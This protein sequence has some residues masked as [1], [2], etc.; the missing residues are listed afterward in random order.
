MVVG[1]SGQ[2]YVAGS[3]G[4][5]VSLPAS[6]GGAQPSFAGGTSDGFVVE[7]SGDLKTIVGSTYVGGSD[8][9]YVKGIA[10]APNGNLYLAGSTFSTDFPMTSQG[11]QP[12]NAGEDDA[13]LAEVSADLTS[14][15]RATYSGSGGLQD[16]FNAVL[17]DASGEVYATGSTQMAVNNVLPQYIVV[18]RFSSDLSTLDSAY[19]FDSSGYPWD[20]GNAITLAPD[21]SVYIAATT[22]AWTEPGT[23]GGAQDFNWNNGRNAGYVA[24]LSHDLSTLVQATFVGGSAYTDLNAIAVDSSG[25]VFVG[26]YASSADFPVTPDAIQTQPPATGQSECTLTEL[27]PDLKAIAWSTFLGGIV[28]ATSGSAACEYGS[29]GSAGQLYAAGD[30]EVARFDASLLD[31]STTSTLAVDDPQDLTV[32]FNTTGTEP[33][34]LS[35]SQLTVSASDSNMT[36]LPTGRFVSTQLVPDGNIVVQGNCAQASNCSLSLTPGQD[37]YG[38]SLVRVAVTDGS[39]YEVVRGFNFTVNPPPAPTITGI[40][41]VTITKGSTSSVSYSFNITGNG[42]LQTTVAVGGTVSKSTGQS[43]CTSAGSCTV[44]LT[45]TANFTGTSKVIIDV[46]DT[47]EQ[48]GVATFTFTIKNPATTGGGGGGGGALGPWDLL[49]LVVLAR[50]MAVRRRRAAH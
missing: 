49:A 40:H 28:S 8:D 3:V 25:R 33:L 42:T 26:G 4:T 21:G 32:A 17:V 10:V 13:F 20:V 50:M 12:A 43:A 19:I 14:I 2:L 11:A 9:D 6:S 35:G 27:T 5:G 37:L 16:S 30:A 48:L 47:F 41:N 46:Y 44:T 36:E 39:N 31:K 29:V 34:T 15:V 45:P 38:T 22:Q 7:L 23:A 18:A 24:H 1:A